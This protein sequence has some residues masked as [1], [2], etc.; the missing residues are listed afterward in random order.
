MARA[1]V[2]GPL[3]QRP[4]EKIASGRPEAPT[5][6]KKGGGPARASTP[7]EDDPA[8]FL[9]EVADATPL[10][11]GPQPPYV[12]PENVK[13][14]DPEEEDRAVRDEL[15][16]LVRGEIRFTLSD[17]QDFIEG[18]VADLDRRTRTRLRRGDFSV[19]GHLDL[20]G[21]NREEGHAALDTFVRAQRLAGKRCL[22]VIHGKGRNSKD[23]QPVLKEQMARWLTRGALGRAVLAFCTAQPADGGAGAIYLLLRR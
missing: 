2:R 10:P 19:Q 3:S 8:L 14:P 13:L 23:G 1:P 21:L 11:R 15:R 7:S 4:F 22:L 5:E 12:P 9:R 6:S 16:A 20:H 17:T 18:A